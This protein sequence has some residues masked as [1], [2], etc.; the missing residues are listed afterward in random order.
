MR[1]NLTS[2]DLDV[3]DAIIMNSNIMGSSLNNY[4]RGNSAV[5]NTIIGGGQFFT[6]DGLLTVKNSHLAEGQPQIINQIT[7]FLTFEDNSEGE[8][9]YTD[10]GNNDFSLSDYSPAIGGGINS[11]ELYSYTYEA[12]SQDFLGNSRPNPE[13]SNVDMGAFENILAE[14]VHNTNI[15]VSTSGTDEDTVGTEDKP[16]LT[17]QAAV[18]YAIE[19]D[20]IFVGPGEYVEQISVLNKGVNLI[21]MEPHSASIALPAT[22]NTLSFSSNIGIINSSIT[23]FNIYPNQDIGGTNGIWAHSD[24]YVS[25]NDCIIRGFDDKAIGTGISSVTVKNSVLIDNRLVLFQD[26][27]SV[28]SLGLVATFYN[29]TIIDHE[30]IYASCVSNSANFVNTIVIGTSDTYSGYTSPPGFNRVITDS[31]LVVPQSNSTWQLA[32]ESFTDMYFTDHENRD[33]TLQNTS[34]AIGYGYYPIPTDIL[35]NSRPAPL[36]TNVD[37]GAYENQLGVPNNAPPRMDE[38]NNV[39]IDEDEGEQNFYITGIVDGDIREIQELSFAIESDNSDLFE[40]ME[41]QYDQGQSIATFS[42]NTS[43]NAYGTAQITVTLSDD[44]G[45]ENDALDFT[46]QT[47]SINVAAVNDQPSEI[48]LINGNTLP[49]NTIDLIV[50]LL[51]TS[52]VDDDSFTYELVSGEGDTG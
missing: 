2:R 25:I 41:I 39:N 5:V 21:S 31:Q 36:G 13:G 4:F 26:N 30:E 9:L 24:H 40:S 1:D 42:F 43:L 22:G 29:S 8:I 48:L 45:T 15:Y 34:P 46:S 27:C 18:N 10:I 16:F 14:T 32:P 35:G 52:D 44:G 20:N 7:N 23:G 28:G 33:Y 50:D 19:G 12:P 11:I 17:I 47:L 37:I 3:T 38:I 49:E 6:N 51:S